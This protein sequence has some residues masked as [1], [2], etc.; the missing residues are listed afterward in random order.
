MT[1]ATRKIQL[2]K[3]APSEYDIFKTHITTA[4][5]KGLYEA[6]PNAA[7]PELEAPVPGEDDY[8]ESLNDPTSTAYFFYL[9]GVN[10][11]GVIVQINPT[12]HY[13]KVD[14]LYINSDAH[15]KGIGQQ[16]WYAIENE[17]PATKAWELVTPYFEKRNIYFYVNKC[18]FKI[19]EFFSE[20]FELGG[21][22]RRFEFFKFVKNMSVDN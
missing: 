21:K 19:T 12:T 5:I 9:N 3:V 6:F 1:Q 17:F 10:V 20:E 16:A 11:G 22:K 14:L 2:V 15:G 13:N 4:F 18:H 7:N 8:V